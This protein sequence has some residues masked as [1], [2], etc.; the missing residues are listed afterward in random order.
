M[1]IDQKDL[2]E[3]FLRYV[4]IDTESDHHSETCPS[5]D[6]QWDLIYF[7]ERELKE[8]GIQDVKVTEFGYVLALIPSNSKKKVP[9]IAFL[10]HVDT[11]DACRGK[12]KPIVH[13]NYKGQPIILPDDPSQILDPKKIPLLK[14][15]IGETLITASGKTLLGA[16]DKAGVAIIMSLVKHLVENPEIIHGPIRICFNPDEEIGRGMNKLEL[17]DLG[18]RAAYTLDSEHLGEI[19]FET[20]SAD[21]ALIEIEGVAAHPGSAKGVLVNAIRLAAELIEKLPSEI[22][23]EMVEGRDGFIHPV[24][25]SGTS[26]KAMIRFIIRDFELDGLDAKQKLLQKIVSDLE[27]ERNGSRIRLVITPQYRNMRYWLEKDFTPVE[28]AQEAIRR[29]GLTPISDA[30]R[31]G[32]DG[33][34]LTE[35]GLPTPNIFT[36]FHN[37]HSTLEWVSLQD[38]EKSVHT[39]IHLSQVWEQS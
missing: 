23:P 8:F 27:K 17:A 2:L 20:F 16:D 14:E 26:E 31:G 18:A 25:I 34:R 39:L 29:A 11:A 1:K 30:I 4:Q 9:Q 19:D 37:I 24:E 13:K 15:K 10:A 33:S 22:F 28:F 7:L 32:T 3:R 6:K 35:R 5:S 12:A 38:M 36:G 21:Q